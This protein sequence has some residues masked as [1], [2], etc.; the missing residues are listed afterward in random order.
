MIQCPWMGR[1]NNLKIIFPKFKK[2]K[3]K[4]HYAILQIFDKNWKKIFAKESMKGDLP[5]KFQNKL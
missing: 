4:F 1:L 3:S 2:S 5:T